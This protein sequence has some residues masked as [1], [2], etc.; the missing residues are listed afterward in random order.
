MSTDFSRR[1]VD[2]QEIGFHQLKRKLTPSDEVALTSGST[3]LNS[4]RG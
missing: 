4:N 3:P 2:H 1:P